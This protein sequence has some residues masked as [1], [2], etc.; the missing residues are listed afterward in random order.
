[1]PQDIALYKERYKDG[2]EKIRD[3][4]LTR[5]RSMGIID[6]QL[7]PLEPDVFPRWNMTPAE[8][9]SQL[10][11]QETGRAV[12]WNSLS[13]S[14][15]EFQAAKMAVHAAMIHRMDIEIGHVLDQIRA[16][17]EL[18]NTIVMFVS[19]NG[20][21]AEQILRGDGSD[22]EAPIGSAPTYLCLGPG[23]SSAS[24]TPF[25]LHKSWAHEGGISTPLIVN[26]PAGIKQ[27]N[28]LRTQPGH[29]IDLVPTLMD[30]TGAKLPDTFAGLP[31]PPL[32]GRSLAPVLRDGGAPPPHDFI[33]WYHDGHRAIAKGNWKLVANFGS[34]WELYD[35]SKDRTET[36]DLAVEHPALVEELSQAWAKLTAGMHE[37]A[38]QDPPASGAL[39]AVDPNAK[40]KPA[41]LAFKFKLKPGMQEAYKKAHD[42][43][44]PEL[45]KA[46]RD[47]GISDY[48]IFLD[49][50]TNTLF[51]V[52]KLSPD[53]TASKLRD[54]EV[55]Q[56]WWKKMVPMMEVNPDTSPVRTPLKEMFHQ[57]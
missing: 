45:S 14:Q 15:Q 17:G 46:I 56:K 29:V 23:W 37:L 8:L 24:N 6:S 1:M 35:L 11:P 20:A 39:P 41:T 43:I 32:Q 49:E 50:E 57:D 44:W 40:V 5:L 42:E 54:T 18:D 21:S 10:S 7:S 27:A 55:L 28:A 48:S 38:L 25:R 26:W 19:D 2:W 4:R 31:V 53:N 52:Q 47:A 13:P 36:K 33:W 9:T 3:E 12:A 22:S 30:L 16:M 34:P 51:A